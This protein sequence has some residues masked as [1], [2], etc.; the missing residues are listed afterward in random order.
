MNGKLQ[1]KSIQEQKSLQ[2]YL[3]SKGSFRDH[4]SR[5]R[6]QIQF[7]TAQSNH[8]VLLNTPNDG[9]QFV[10]LSQTKTPEEFKYS[11]KNQS[12]MMNKQQ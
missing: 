5:A 9:T 12:F 10:F 3:M 1:V 7:D 11:E 2:V 8:V 4:Y 6:D